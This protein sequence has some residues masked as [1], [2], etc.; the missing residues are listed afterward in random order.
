MVAAACPGAV[1]WVGSGAE[2]VFISFQFLL[3]WSSSSSKHELVS[4]WP[5]EPSEEQAGLEG[6]GKNS[7]PVQ[8]PAP[9]GREVGSSG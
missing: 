6:R 4:P 9:E 8:S 5:G 1:P 7:I 2:E 3:G